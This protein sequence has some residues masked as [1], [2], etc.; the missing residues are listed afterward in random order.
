[1]VEVYPL[2]CFILCHLD[3]INSVSFQF[4]TYKFHIIRT[5]CFEPVAINT[6]FYENKFGSPAKDVNLLVTGD[7]RNFNFDDNC[8]WLKQDGHVSFK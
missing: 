2:F 4:I 7:V 8:V 3:V 1:M 5:S 6:T